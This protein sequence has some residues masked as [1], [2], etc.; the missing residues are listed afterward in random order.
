MVSGHGAFLPKMAQMNNK[1]TGDV[2][3]D[4][5]LIMCQTMPELLMVGIWVVMVRTSNKEDRSR[6]L[7]AWCIPSHQNFF[8]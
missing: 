2:A 6:D 1:G 3:G 8:I 5:G 4:G 7:A